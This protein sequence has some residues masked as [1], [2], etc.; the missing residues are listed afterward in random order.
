MKKLLFSAMALCLATW[1]FGQVIFS[2]I[3]PESI[4]GNYNFSWAP[5]SAGWGSPDFNTPGT[6]IQGTLKIVEDGT[7]GTNDQGHPISQE[8]CSPLTND[9]TGKIAVVYRNTCEFGAKA[10]NAQDAGAIGVIVI[11]RD[12]EVINMGAGADGANVTIPVVMLTNTDGAALV[13]EMTNG[14]VEVFIGN[15]TGLFDNDIALLSSA[16]LRP[17]YGAI[18]AML[19]QNG[20]EFNFDLGARIYN[21]GSLAQSGVSISAVIT[22]PSSTVVYNQTI[23]DLSIAAGD[24]L[25][26]DPT[27]GQSLPQFSLSNYPA[28][29]Y[30]LTYTI[31]L[32]DGTTDEYDADN[33]ITTTFT[34]TQNVYSFGQV[35]NPS[36]LPEPGN[37][38]R[39]S[40]N[41]QTF[42]IC[43]VLND[44]NASRAAATGLYFA[45]TSNNDVDLA[46]EEIALYLYRWNDDFADLNSP[47]FGFTSLEEVA[48]GFYY[49]PSNDLQGETV[50]GVFNTPIALQN[51]T[52]YL[53][54]AQTTN[55]NVFLGHE[56]RTDYTWNLDYYLQPLTPNESDGTYFAA[57]FG[58]DVPNSLAIRLIDVNTIGLGEEATL[59]GKA[60]PNPANDK[61]TI[62]IEGEGL[63]SITALDLSGKVCL[64]SS[65]IL[66][67]GNVE[68]NI[69]NL[70]SGLYIFN[71]VLE[72]GKTAKFNVVKR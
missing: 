61:L 35:N 1:S 57:G 55:L 27:S 9:L 18:P 47:G 53:A 43:S 25:D 52:R 41:N 6:F 14:D 31:N 12:P 68:L 69:D 11:N 23:N 10:K 8:G 54:C 45:A 22:N 42:S 28:G 62:S 64:T 49:F 58:A 3:S 32:A 15:K 16:V 17:K 56:S 7:P 34:I 63:A 65:S 40:T 70:D 26:V 46:G 20:T 48:S 21:P 72:N 13:A 5:P 50:Y 44:A 39:P 2:G 60:F 37:F 51:N 30:T 38:Y 24:S 33:I 19:A 29:T 71:V 67:N 66:N 4:A 59:E 36:G